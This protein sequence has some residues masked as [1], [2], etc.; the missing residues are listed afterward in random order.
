MKPSRRETMPMETIYVV[1]GIT[2]AFVVFALA[3][4]YA[5]YTSS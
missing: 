5:S 1:S 3:L 2:A 4:A